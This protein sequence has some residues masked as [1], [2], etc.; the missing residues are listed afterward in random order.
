MPSLPSSVL[1]IMVIDDEE[2]LSILFDNFIKALGFDSISFTNPLQALEHF[3]AN[4]DKFS[5]VITDMRMPGLCG[6]ELANKVRD[7]NES[8]KIFLITAFDT[9]ELGKDGIN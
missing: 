6:L 1:S 4:L 7:L 9:D 3:K 5:I 8:V 2:E